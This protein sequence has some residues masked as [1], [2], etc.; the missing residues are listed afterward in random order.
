MQSLSVCVRVCNCVHESHLPPE[1]VSPTIS[2]LLFRRASEVNTPDPA[3]SVPP[4][5]ESVFSVWVC[6]CVQPQLRCWAGDAE[7]EERS[8]KG[9]QRLGV[10][11]VCFCWVTR[12]G[13]RK[14][15]SR[16]RKSE[17]R[18]PEVRDKE[19]IRRSEGMD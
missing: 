4:P 14:T 8:W 6:V 3:L 16:M 12:N 13:R 19:M 9:Q 7:E 11:S 2:S 1:G 15:R 18:L 10:V 17:A 5:P